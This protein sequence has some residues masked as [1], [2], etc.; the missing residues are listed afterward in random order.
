MPDLIH[1]L[2]D[3]DPAML[4]IIAGKWGLALERSSQLEAAKELASMMFP[5][6]NKTPEAFLNFQ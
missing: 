3:H 5:M 6:P 2:I 1:L 4:K